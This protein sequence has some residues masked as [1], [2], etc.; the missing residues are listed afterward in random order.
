[1]PKLW[2][3]R[4]KKTSD[5]MMNR[6]G[7]SIAFDKVLYEADI[8]GSIAYARALKKIGIF[9]DGGYARVVKALKQILREFN[10]GKFTIQPSDEDIHTAIERRLTETIG[11]LGRK[12]HT[13]RSRNDQVATDV[14]LFLMW[15]VDE[16]IKKIVDLQKAIL[17]RAEKETDVVMPG[18]T[19]LQ[20]AQPI[21]WS[22]YLMSLFWMLQR[23]KE[24]FLDCKLR[25]SVLPLG[26][27]AIA[28][29]AFPIDRKALAKELGFERVS[30]NSIDAVSDRDF[31]IEF[32]S[33]CAILMTHISR[34]AEDLIIWSSVEFGFVEL[35]DAYATGSS[36]MPQKKNPDSLELVRGKTGRVIGNLTALLAVVK[37]LPL[38]YAKDLQEDKEPL[39]DTIETVST[40]LEVLKGVLKTMKIR[41]DKMHAKMDET[42]FATDL[43]DYLV[44]KGL[45][46][47]DAHKI[48][49][50]LVRWLG[51]EGKKFSKL[52]LRTYKRFSALFDG[53]V[54]NLFDFRHSVNLRSVEGGT[55][56]AS[57]MKQIRKGKELL[58]KQ[59]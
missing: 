22:H 5:E 59:V 6:F 24:R 52:P 31:I 29:N 20:Q 45:P 8:T 49:G 50:K 54:Y 26:S 34:Y 9:T 27:G 36:M 48:V 40:S 18:Y 46:F 13:G 11:N 47:R 4:F 51:E 37:G 57:V 7:N 3:D 23:D 58:R 39:F 44:K 19:H 42:M 30:E 56:K 25:S 28:G 32:L 16:I 38:T 14:R 1:M 10:G 15:K 35:D 33:A 12:I 2:E 43:A 41:P 55:S 17:R 53:D 21:L